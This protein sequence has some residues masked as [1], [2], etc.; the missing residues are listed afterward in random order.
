MKKNIAP[1]LLAIF[2][3]G[4]IVIDKGY[5]EEQ[6]R[7]H[8]AALGLPAD[9]RVVCMGT[10]SNGDGYVSCT[11][12]VPQAGGGAPQMQAIECASSR[13]GCG[14]NQGCRIPKGRL[15]TEAQ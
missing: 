8:V 12:S 15:A 13:N 2:V 4:C 7:E 14:M 9:T 6:G 3:A 11:I 10:D 5:A 1:L